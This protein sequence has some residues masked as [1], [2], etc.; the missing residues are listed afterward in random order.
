MCQ[1]KITSQNMTFHY[2]FLLFM[3][4]FEAHLKRAGKGERLFSE[5]VSCLQTV[6]CKVR[7]PWTVKVSL[8][9]LFST[10]HFILR[11]LFTIFVGKIPPHVR[12]QNYQYTHFKCNGKKKSICALWDTNP[13]KLNHEHSWC[14]HYD[15]LVD[16]L[17]YNKLQVKKKSLTGKICETQTL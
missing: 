7:R 10:F 9:H 14:R 5:S 3:T 11:R 15:K 6:V 1:N 4:I 12:N 13:N 2:R 17:V 16:F 8:T